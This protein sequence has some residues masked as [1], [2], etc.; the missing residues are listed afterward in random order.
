MAAGDEGENLLRDALDE[1]E[2]GEWAQVWLTIRRSQRDP[3]TLG[4]PPEA[5][6][7]HVVLPPRRKIP[8][9]E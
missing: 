8:P 4:E 2:D 7:I 9:A 3:R 6:E 1:I 5:N